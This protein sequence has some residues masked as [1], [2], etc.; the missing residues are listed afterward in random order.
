[1]YMNTNSQFIRPVR[2]AHLSSL[3]LVLCLVAAGPGCKKK[4][5]QDGPDEQGTIH[6]DAG[7]SGPS[8]QRY[9]SQGAVTVERKTKSGNDGGAAV[10]KREYKNCRKPKPVTSGDPS[11]PEGTLY[12]VFSALLE[13]DDETAFS[14]FYA[15]IDEDFQSERDA[16]R[17]WF[18]AAR[19]D[20]SKNFL[21]LVYSAT[22]PSYDMCSQRPEGQDAVRIFVGKSP[23]VGSNPPYVLKKKGDKW[24]LKTFTPH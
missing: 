24:L 21:R 8:D 14:K 15:L 20:N 17:Y 1:M 23:P 16:R 18:A 12:L 11:T 4:K 13:K 2:K 22:D 3:S 10:T 9:G 7:M 6:A 19:K 5:Y